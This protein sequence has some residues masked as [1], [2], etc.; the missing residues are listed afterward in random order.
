MQQ[1]PNPPPARY[2]KPPVSKRRKRLRAVNIGC[3]ASIPFLMIFLLGTVCFTEIMAIPVLAVGLGLIPFF[4]RLNEDTGEC[5]LLLTVSRLLCIGLLVL[6]AAAPVICLNFD[7]TQKMYPLKKLVFA[8][9]VKGSAA[10]A[11]VHSLLPDTLPDVCSDYQFRTQ[12]C[13]IAP[14]SG[15]S[16]YLFFYTD[17]QTLRQYAGQLEA[18]EGMNCAH[19]EPPLRPAETADAETVPLRG[20]MPSDPYNMLVK[21]KGFAPDLRYAYCYTPSSNVSR[22]WFGKCVIIDYNSG[23]FAVWA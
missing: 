19:E 8:R 17:A 21:W 5:R 15:Q 7:G 16:A 6:T 20:P 18:A 3:A 4:F 2:A 22:N 13:T 11:A 9:G 1:A 10:A 23:L 12:P 14:G